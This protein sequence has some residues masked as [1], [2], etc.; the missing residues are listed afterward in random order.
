MYNTVSWLGGTIVTSS[1]KVVLITGAS[2]GI[3]KACA[4]R[5]AQRG[6]RVFG[7]SRH[8]AMPPEPAPSG[9]V[10]MV[11]MDVNDDESV[12]QGVESVLH[13]AGR[14]DVVGSE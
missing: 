5:L 8:A 2:S 3:G 14:L 6:Y 4:E 11:R 13:Q 1:D 7:T 12:R 10:T 9:A